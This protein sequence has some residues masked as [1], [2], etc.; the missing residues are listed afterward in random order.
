M[1]LTWELIAI[2]ALSL[3]NFVSG[4]FLKR[5]IAQIDDMNQSLQ[6]LAIC[7]S[8]QNERWVNHE[9]AHAEHRQ[10]RK[11]NDKDLWSAIQDLRTN[12]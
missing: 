3:A 8:K 1:Q 4:L 9:R 2:G 5:L 6:R 12:R 7:V 10:D 11:A